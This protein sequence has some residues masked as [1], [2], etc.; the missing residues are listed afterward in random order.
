MNQEMV[1]KDGEIAEQKVMV[2]Q[3]QEVRLNSS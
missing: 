3:L 1:R 2:R